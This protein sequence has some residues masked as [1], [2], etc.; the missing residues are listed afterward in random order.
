MSDL[1]EKINTLGLSVNKRLTE[2]LDEMCD[3]G[4][5]KDAMSYSLMAGGKRLRPAL[6]LISAEMFG[7]ADEALDLACAMEMIHTY[8]LIHDDLPAMD[9]D[10]FRRGR[11]TNHKVFG[12]AYAILA[13]DALLNCAFEVMLRSALNNKD[14]TLN[15]IGAID[16]IAR[17]AGVKGMI[18]GQVADIEFEDTEQ[19][20]DVLEYIH[21]RKTAAILMASVTSGAALMGASEDDLEAL[22]K[23]GQCIGLVFQIID[24]V[25]DET[26]DIDKLGKTPGKDKEEG[27]QTFLRLYGMEKSKEIAAQ[28]TEEAV[29]ALSCFGEKAESFKKLAY[30]LLKR[31]H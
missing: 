14:K 23:Y 20:E 30:Y 18:A 2:L 5:L 6:C 13:G 29:K 31:D 1:S 3:P 25:L 28:K 17:A 27:K 16:I 10:D 15:Y 19:G 11:P 4:I 7:N 24:D 9:N 26:G 12:E 8:S 22:R 21:E